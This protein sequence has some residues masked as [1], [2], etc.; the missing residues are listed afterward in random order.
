MLLLLGGQRMNTVYFFPVNRMTV[1]VIGV[2]FSPNQ[3][4]KHSEQAKKLDSFHCM[5][6]H[7]KKLCVA[8]CLNE[9]WKRRSTKEQTDTKALFIT[10]AKLS[11]TATIDSKRR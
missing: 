1:T 8:D 7:N 4:I 2:I 3:V 10:Y 6:C 5:A 11:R 9:Y